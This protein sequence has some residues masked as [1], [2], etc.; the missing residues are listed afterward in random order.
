MAVGPI[1]LWDFLL[2]KCKVILSWQNRVALIT[3]DFINRETVG[4]QDSTVIGQMQPYM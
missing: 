2:R 3:I 4:R 1:K